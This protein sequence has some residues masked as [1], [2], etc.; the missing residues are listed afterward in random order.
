M[1]VASWKTKAPTSLPNTLTFAAQSSLPKLP[2]PPLAD[3]LTRLKESL[4]PLAWTQEELL[5]AGRKIDEFGSSTGMG[6]ILQQRL[7]G[8]AK[9]TDH[10]LEEWWDDAGYLAYRDS[11]S[12]PSLSK[13]CFVFLIISLGRGERILL[14]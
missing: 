2:V 3:S 9:E 4:R 6:R 13:P 11:V 10:W 14:L 12:P 5:A 8:R 7:E 1:T